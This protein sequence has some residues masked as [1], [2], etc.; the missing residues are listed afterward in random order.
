M[1]SGRGAIHPPTNGYRLRPLCYGTSWDNHTCFRKL[2][3]AW[4]IFAT[5]VPTL[6][7]SRASKTPMPH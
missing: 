4:A 2:L 3:Y 7:P 1:Y 5:E 6:N